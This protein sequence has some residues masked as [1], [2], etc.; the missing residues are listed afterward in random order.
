MMISK[1]SKVLDKC[2]RK[3]GDKGSAFH[4]VVS[5]VCVVVAISAIVN[6]QDDHICHELS[7][8]ASI[9]ERESG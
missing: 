1:V 2:E 6:K 5:I 3:P 4:K 9:Y 7:L 8:L